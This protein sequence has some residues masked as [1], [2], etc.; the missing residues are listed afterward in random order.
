MGMFGDV[1]LKENE[2]G[3]NLTDWLHRLWPTSIIVGMVLVTVVGG[4]LLTYQDAPEERRPVVVVRLG[5]TQTPLPG[6]TPVPLPTGTPVPLPTSTPPSPPSSTPTSSPTVKPVTATWTPQATPVPTW[7]PTFTPTP[8][9]WPTASWGLYIV[10]PEDTLPTLA[11][12][13]GTS[14]D[15]IMQAN[16]L[17]SLVIY[18]GQR[19]YLPPVYVTPAPTL[20]PTP[21]KPPIGGKVRAYPTAPFSDELHF[22]EVPDGTSDRSPGKP[23]YPRYNV[24][25]DQAAA[26]AR[27][28]QTKRRASSQ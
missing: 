5:P 22:V 6:A 19:L 12:H 18:P 17:S 25:A 23:P 3:D 26:P 7:T 24:G 2:S 14:P 13:H 16:Y 10:Q 27:T 11:A 8:P 4:L 28:S 9:Y 1:E 15:A 21:C 20:S